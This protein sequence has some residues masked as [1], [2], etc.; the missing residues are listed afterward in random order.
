MAEGVEFATFVR[1]HTRAL[2]GTAIL[3]TGDRAAAE[4]LLQDTLVRLYPRWHRVSEAELPLAYVRRSLTNNFLNGRRGKNNAATREVLRPEAPEAIFEPD[5]AGRI[6]EADLVRELL[7]SLPDRQRAVLVLR[8]Y[9]DLSDTEIAAE[10][11]IRPGTVRSIVSRSLAT[12]RA[13]TGGR[14]QSDP[15][16]PMRGRAS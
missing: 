12:L 14:D 15:S 13:Q 16:E 2:L 10:L 9:Q 5:I 6:T 1:V 7:R 3:L 8:F 11:H 4:D